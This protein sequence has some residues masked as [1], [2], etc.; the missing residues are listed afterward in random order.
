MSAT[1]FLARTLPVAVLAGLL[2]GCISL[3]PKSK[4]AQLY[5]F[6]GAP[7]PITAPGALDPGRFAVQAVPTSFDRASAGDAILTIT[8]DEAAY[9]AGSRWV[10]SATSLFDAAVTRAFDADRGPARLIAR[11][12]AVRPAYL[13]KLDVRA[14]EAR[15]DQ[16]AAAPPTVVVEVYA[17]LSKAS[18]R[19][20]AGE[21]IFQAKVRAAENRAG[22]ITQAFDQA[23]AKVLGDLVAWVDGRG[24]G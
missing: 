12:E 4:P 2:A 14:F 5:R 11:G 16:G 7:A 8:G 10:S 22:A 6:G 9:I 24:A 19:T 13:L 20:L 17:A 1:P 3:L 18:D 21:R 23:T 15:Y